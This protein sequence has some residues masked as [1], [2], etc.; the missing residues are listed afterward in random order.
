MLS[1]DPAR[2]LSFSPFSLSLNPS[3]LSIALTILSL[4]H[5]LPLLSSLL[6]SLPTFRSPAPNIFLPFLTKLILSPINLFFLPH[7]SLTSFFASPPPLSF[8]QPFVLSHCFPSFF[9]FFSLESLLSFSLP[10]SHYL[11]VEIHLESCLRF[12]SR[13]WWLLGIS[14]CPHQRIT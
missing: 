12:V 6:P 10:L 7:Y 8:A 9:L 14:L 4:L 3:F 2:S 11:A 13:Q 1:S 5:S